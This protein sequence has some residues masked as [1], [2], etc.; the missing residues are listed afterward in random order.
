MF[1]FI[2][3]DFI[4]LIVAVALII[5]Y[6]FIGFRRK[7]RLKNSYQRRSEQEKQ[8]SFSKKR[9]DQID[10]TGFG[11]FINNLFDFQE[12]EQVI[13]KQKAYNQQFTQTKREQ[14]IVTSLDT[15]LAK[16]DKPIAP[17]T[18]RNINKKKLSASSPD[19]GLYAISPRKL[20]NAIIWSEILKPPKGLE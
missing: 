5:W 17:S 20:R 14:R 16:K 3:D 7:E 10:K 13:A 8:K 11:Y 15:V 4:S 9:V 19:A 1:D 12:P 6:I 18:K 2:S